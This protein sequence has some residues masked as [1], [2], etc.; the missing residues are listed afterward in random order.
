MEIARAKAEGETLKWEDI[1]KMK[2]SWNVACEVLRI[3]SPLQGAFR[4]AL[5]DFVFNGFFIPK[6]W[7]VMIKITFSFAISFLKIS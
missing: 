1:K 7:K 4:E 2:Y 3:A 5:S 6:G